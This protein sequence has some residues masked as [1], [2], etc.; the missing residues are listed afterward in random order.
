MILKK[1]VYLLKK[2]ALFI[3]KKAT[4]ID[5]DNSNTK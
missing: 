3:F 2:I 1:L 5:Y 4:N